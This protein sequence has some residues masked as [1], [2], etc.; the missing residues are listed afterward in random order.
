MLSVTDRAREQVR[1]LMEK[2][3]DGVLGLRLSTP[4]RGCSGLAYHLDYIQEPEPGDEMVDVAGTPLYIDG[5]SVLYLVGSEMDWREDTFVSGFVF[6][7]PNEKG[8][9]GCGESFTI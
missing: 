4:K 7:N 6:T 8:R 1:A 3:D 2:A 5:A 9:C